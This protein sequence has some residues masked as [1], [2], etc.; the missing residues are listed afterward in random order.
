MDN[1]AAEEGG[2]PPVAGKNNSIPD[3]T[4]L[5]LPRCGP[6]TLSRDYTA[7]KLIVITKLRFPTWTSETMLMVPSPPPLIRPL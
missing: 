1:P 7:I 3:E 6:F 5:D 2:L 4:S